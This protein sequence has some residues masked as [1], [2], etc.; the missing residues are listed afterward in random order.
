MSDRLDA[1]ETS[2]EEELYTNSLT[3]HTT[4]S[5]STTIGNLSFPLGPITSRVEEP[6]TLSQTE[7]QFSSNMP[8]LEGSTQFDN[9]GTSSNTSIEDS[10]FTSHSIDTQLESQITSPTPSFPRRNTRS[11]T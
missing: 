11:T 6:S 4:A 9:T 5:N 1:D 8:Y 10:V 2:E 3:S 7:S